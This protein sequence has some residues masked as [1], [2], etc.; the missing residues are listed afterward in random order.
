MAE[1]IAQHKEIDKKTAQ[2][3]ENIKRN[4]R[5]NIDYYEKKKD[6]LFP[7]RKVLNLKDN[8][9]MVVYLRSGFL[10]V[11]I[12]VLKGCQD[13]P[14][15][16]LHQLMIDVDAG[17]FDESIKEAIARNNFKRILSRRQKDS[18]KHYPQLNNAIKNYINDKD[19]AESRNAKDY[20]IFF[21]QV[22]HKFA[23]R[24]SDVLDIRNC[25][26]MN[27]FNSSNDDY[28]MRIIEKYIKN[29]FRKS[30]NDAIYLAKKYGDAEVDNEGHI[31]DKEIDYLTDTQKKELLKYPFL[32]SYI[33]D[34]IRDMAFYPSFFE[35]SEFTMFFKRLWNECVD[36][37][38]LF[39][40]WEDDANKYYADPENCSGDNWYANFNSCGSNSRWSF[41]EEYIAVNFSECVDNAIRLAKKYGDID[42]HAKKIHLNNSSD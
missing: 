18:L 19:I 22:Y 3:R 35:I 23:I 7:A 21:K 1:E 25:D 16:I 17:K 32:C 5:D 29:H 28:R 8:N 15:E 4:I 14:L 24:P 40:G 26:K 39:P 11:F 13:S 33:N 34:Y 2:I 30:V 27:K 37:L 6:Y 38:E 36:E 12:G 41:G 31:T 20:A 42:I 10:P 9:I